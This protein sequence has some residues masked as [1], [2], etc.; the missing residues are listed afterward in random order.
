MSIVTRLYLAM[1]FT[2]SLIIVIGCVT[3]IQSTQISSVFKLYSQSSDTSLKGEKV[4]EELSAA[5]IAALKYRF[6]GNPDN[7]AEVR[8]SFDKAGLLQE[9][10]LQGQADKSKQQ[11]LINLPLM[12]SDYRSNLDRVASLQV[13]YDE[14][15][16][17]AIFLGQKAREQLTEVM[18]SAFADADTEASHLAG[19]ASTS[20][21]RGRLY[22]ERFKIFQ[23][24]EY[25]ETSRGHI[26]DVTDGLS[27]LLDALQSPRRRELITATIADVAQFRT[28]TDQIA[29][30]LEAQNLA[31]ANMDTIGPKAIQI[32]DV[33]VEGALSDQ[34]GY[35]DDALGSARN[36]IFMVIALVAG[37]TVIGAIVSVSI[38]RAISKDLARMTGIMTRVSVGDL[39]V[40]IEKSDKD[41]ELGKMNNAMVVFLDNA[42]KNREM[43]ENMAAAKETEKSRLAAERE[44]EAAIERETKAARDREVAAQNKRTEALD[45][46]QADIEKTIGQAAAGNFSSR[47]SEKLDYD[48]LVTLAQLINEL[49]D[50]TG[51][52]ISDVVDSI[53][54]LAEGDLGTRINGNQ[55][56]AFL[57]L[58]TDFN[59]ALEKL[60]MSMS[61]ITQNGFGVS[62]GSSELEQAA[63]SMAKRAED[64]ATAIEETSAAAE[65]LSASVQQVVAN[66]KAADDATKRVRE[67]ANETRNVSNKTEESIGALSDAST[68]INTVVKVIEDIA[69]QI[70]LLALN[71]GVE[72]AR[73]GEAGRGFSVVASEVRALAQR[74]QEAVQEI[75]AVIIENKKTVDESVKQ[76][77]LSRA[78]VDEIVSEVE[79]ASTQISEIA[80]AVEQQ[81][82]G[83]EEINS[84]IQSIDSTSQIN[85]AALEEMTASSVTLSNEA[86][87]LA[88][89]LRM[90]K[91]VDQSS[92]VQPA[93]FV[94]MKRGADEKAAQSV[95]S[96]QMPLQRAVA[97]GAAATSTAEQ[98]EEF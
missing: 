37:A 62:T 81:S 32:M 23:K 7:L 40:D 97:G 47:M 70:N 89:T 83:I 25:L 64:G 8:E 93:K 58:K 68:R 96:K 67:R 42:L 80:S 85:A 21:M 77:G 26:A 34:K 17:E 92:T 39:D 2:I 69:F 84:A 59:S 31:F 79:V 63:L 75:S 24:Q 66:A 49:L 28:V 54:S 95:A 6:N 53:G 33:V 22:M 38:G 76:V 43:T 86:D 57:T 98:W 78:A 13:Q 72:A 16:G 18:E 12:L 48:D 46:F 52:N 73:A 30:N 82:L 65:E 51:N 4:I 1:A 10:I 87:T 60:S 29:E 45:S 94:P 5:R 9:E 44:K 3:T 36:S 55:S 15:V 41:H 74:S 14:M 61:Q 88:K 91:G 90:F 11:G 56:G 71:A 20:L 50:V 35:R 27:S 19:L